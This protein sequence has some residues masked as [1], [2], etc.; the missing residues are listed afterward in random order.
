MSGISK[1]Y[2]SYLQNSK[3]YG[4]ISLRKG[5]K[6]SMKLIKK[7][8]TK[9]VVNPATGVS[10]SKTY[11]NVILVTDSGLQIPIKSSFA[12]DSRLLRSLAQDDK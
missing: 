9:D 4:T 6:G 8:V 1:L 10:E 3:Q 5:G 12:N 2:K 7:T 11:V